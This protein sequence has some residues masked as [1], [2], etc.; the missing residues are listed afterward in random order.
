M[1][2]IITFKSEI[3][4]RDGVID[5]TQLYKD[6]DDFMKT[7]NP[8]GKKI[9]RKHA[10]QHILNST[11]GGYCSPTAMKSFELCPASYIYNKLVTEKTG[12]A[13]S[14]G[15]TCHTIMEKFYNEEG[16]NR[17]KD[18]L[19][20]IMEETIKEDKQ[21]DGYASVKAHIDGYV[22]SRDYLTGKPVLD[23]AKEIICSNEQFIKPTINPLGVSLNVPVYL[24]IDRIDVREDGIYVIDYKTGL[25]DPNPYNLGEYGYLPQMIFYKWGV[26]AE[27]GQDI[28]KAF[29]C[30]PGAETQ[31]YKFTEMNVNSLVEQSKVV[32]QVYR[33]L[34][35]IRKD[36]DTKMFETTCMRYCGSCQMK[37]FCSSFIKSKNLEDAEGYEI[38]ETIPVEM[39]VEIPEFKDSEEENV[40][41]EVESNS[42]DE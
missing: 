23:V 20:E 17:T 26:E 12:T 27:Y 38:K 31:K 25:G 40:N 29:L 24:L 28:K 32:E 8:E 2:D 39:E 16:E 36:R 7:Y 3:Y 35:H 18:R 33:H 41:P 13:T 6:I 4:Q 21:E 5:T 19:Y 1:A 11:S 22:E 14:I 34:E 10:L 9:E 42:D 15:R 30:L 37:Y